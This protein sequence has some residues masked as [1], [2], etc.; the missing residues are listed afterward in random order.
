[1]QVLTIDYVFDQS[2]KDVERHAKP[3]SAQGGRRKPWAVTDSKGQRSK[4]QNKHNNDTYS[5]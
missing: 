3:P 4:I 2:N 5:F 1:M